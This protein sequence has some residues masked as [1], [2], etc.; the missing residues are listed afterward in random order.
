V[1]SARPPGEKDKP[2][3]YHN[4]SLNTALTASYGIIGTSP[5]LALPRHM[6]Y[7]TL[8]LEEDLKV[9]GPV[10]ISLYASTTEKVTSDWSFFV[11]MGEMVPGG[12]PL[13]PVTGNPEIKPDK[14]PGHRL[15]C[16]SGAGVL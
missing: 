11:K 16:R 4:I 5:K 3:I 1:I 13:N 6:A 12:V 14:S 9:W 2:D 15:K 10:R 8:P 7:I